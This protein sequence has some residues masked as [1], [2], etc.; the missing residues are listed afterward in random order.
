MGV[1]KKIMWHCLLETE[2]V[3]MEVM[4]HTGMEALETEHV[5]MEVMEHTRMEVLETEHMN[6]EWK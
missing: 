1:F 5:R 4:E 2:H 3:R 6:E